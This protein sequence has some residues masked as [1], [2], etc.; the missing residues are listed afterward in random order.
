MWPIVS[1]IDRVG[2]N[3]LLISSFRNKGRPWQLVS[4]LEAE[5]ESNKKGRKKRSLKAVFTAGINKFTF[6]KPEDKGS[7]GLP[8]DD[9]DGLRRSGRRR[10]Q[11]QRTSSI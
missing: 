5:S 4:A 2:A 1:Y 9:V 7:E 11:T 10:S 3:N 6:T 8:F